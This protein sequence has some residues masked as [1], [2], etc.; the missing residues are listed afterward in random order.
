MK[1]KTAIYIRVSTDKQESSEELQKEKC[2]AYCNMMGYDVVDILTD[3]NVSGGIELFKRPEG[4][5]L[6]SLSKMVK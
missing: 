2:L 4:A 5:K 6:Y 1:T 3:S